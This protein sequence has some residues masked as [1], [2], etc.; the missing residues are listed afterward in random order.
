MLDGLTEK[1]S[2]DLE[3]QAEFAV[4]KE[5]KICKVLAATVR[6]IDATYE[7]GPAQNYVL[8]YADVPN[9][10]LTGSDYLF[11]KEII[12]QALREIGRELEKIIDPQNIQHIVRTS[13]T[14]DSSK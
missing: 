8:I 2:V 5:S 11:G 1:K 7:D 3:E 14:N 10:L 6:G 12:V 9:R 4:P 13:E